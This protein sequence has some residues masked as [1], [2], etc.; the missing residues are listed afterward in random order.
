MYS[1]RFD[2]VHFAFTN[3]A[4]VKG[5]TTMAKRKKAV[6]KS[7]SSPLSQVHGSHQ[8]RSALAVTTAVILLAIFMIPLLVLGGF[9]L[10]QALAMIEQNPKAWIIPAMSAAF[11][12]F[13]VGLWFY[14]IWWGFW[15]PSVTCYRFALIGNQ[16]E[17][18]TRK[19]G[20]KIIKVGDILTCKKR[21][22]KRSL[23]GVE[24]VLGW[25]LRSQAMGWVYLNE[26]TS[27]SHNLISCIPAA[28]FNSSPTE[29]ELS[30]KPVVDN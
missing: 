20:A 13:F 29:K 18:R 22:A 23:Y 27:N 15:V 19:H 4:S 2:L 16:L 5:Q 25:W 28:K 9:L 12:V 7:A 3:N 17:I 8:C 26:R 11:G 14:V 30:S 10:Y 1:D 21:I 6:W 24:R